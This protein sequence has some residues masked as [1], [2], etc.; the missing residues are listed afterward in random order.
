M[1]SDPQSPLKAFVKVFSF[2]LA[3]VAFVVADIWGVAYI[4]ENVS[5]PLAV[6]YGAVMLAIFLGAIAAW[7]E[8]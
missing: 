4:G 8:R 1:C 6:A 7:S 5:E 3:G 2:T